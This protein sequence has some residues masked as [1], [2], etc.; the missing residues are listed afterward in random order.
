MFEK[1]KSYLDDNDEMEIFL[2]YN[3]S[4]EISYLK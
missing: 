4:E 1:D 3:F 2:T